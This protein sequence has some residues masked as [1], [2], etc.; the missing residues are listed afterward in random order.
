MICGIIFRKEGVSMILN[1]GYLHQVAHDKRL[2]LEFA[3]KKVLNENVQ[4]FRKDSKDTYDIFLSHSYLDK[5]L[6]YTVVDLFNQAGYSVYVDW[7]EDQQLDRSKVNAATANT[8]RERMEL[9]KSLAYVATS[10]SSNSK[11][12][13]WE[14][15]YVDA[16]KNGR[17]AILPIMKDDSSTFKGQEYL[18]LYPF[19]DYAL[20]KNTHTYEFWVN[21]PQSGKYISLGEWLSGANP[22]NHNS[23]E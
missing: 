16:L 23:Q 12:C 22:Y 18:G 8:L 21:D 20:N 14:L 4:R 5:T 1:E 13:P 3:Q 15:G 9:S 19:I 17:C 10:N 6:V 11:W 7:I 2:D